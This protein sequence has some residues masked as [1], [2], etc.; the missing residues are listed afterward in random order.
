[1]LSDQVC[2]HC[3]RDISDHYSLCGIILTLIFKQIG[4]MPQHDHHQ[5]TVHDGED[6]VHPE[7]TRVWC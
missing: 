3:F 4:E 5:H 7:D 6:R 1:M 2:R